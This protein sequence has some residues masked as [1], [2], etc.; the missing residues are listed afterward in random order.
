MFPKMDPKTMAKMM[1]QMGIKN[2][3]VDASRVTVELKD[4]SLLVVD[5]PNVMVISMQGQE[6]L[7]V[8]GA[9][10]KVDANQAAN[11]SSR[12]GSLVSPVDAEKTDVDIVM[13]QTGCSRPEAEKALEENGGDLAG[14][15]LKLK[16]Q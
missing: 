12:A 11:A 10:Q 4:G 5:N 14:A 3:P 16:A 9:I 1:A 7:Q 15:I 13:E 8:T 2:D 6:S